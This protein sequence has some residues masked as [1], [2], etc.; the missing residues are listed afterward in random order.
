MDLCNAIDRKVI[1]PRG[2]SDCFWGRPIV[3]T[4]GLLFVLAHVGM[5]PGYLL[6]GIVTHD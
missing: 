2:L 3:D 5:D 6:L 4:I 1:A